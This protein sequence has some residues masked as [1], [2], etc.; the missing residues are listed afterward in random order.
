MNIRGRTIV[1]PRPDARNA[2]S[3]SIMY[4]AT[5]LDRSPVSAEPPDIST[6][7]RTPTREASGKMSGE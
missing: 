5:A 2:S 6:T 7:R 1:Q 3:V 4:L